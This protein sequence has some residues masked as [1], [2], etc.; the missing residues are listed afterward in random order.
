MPEQIPLA[1]VV[2][3]APDPPALASFYERLLGW[4]IVQGD[5]NWV[6]MEGPDGSSK[7]SIQRE[8]N[9][10]PP[11]WPSKTDRQQMQI[12]LDFKVTDLEAAQQLAVEAGATAMD[13][14]PQEEGVRIFADPVGHIF[15]LF[16]P[17]W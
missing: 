4:K 17:G 9:Y 12:H 13:W 8:P 6:S 16:L 11:S 15:C 14:Q 5:H 10:Q 2:L 1:G 3:D 7:L